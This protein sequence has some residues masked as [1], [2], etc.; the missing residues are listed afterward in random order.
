M[1][2]IVGLT[3]AGK[4]TLVN[5][6][7]GDYVSI[8]TPKPQTTRESLRAILHHGKSQIILTD[9]P[10]FFDSKTPRQH[11]M[12][13][14]ARRVIHTSEALLLLIDCLR[15]PPIHLL[16]QL[17]QQDIPTDKK[18]VVLNKIDRIDKKKL[19]PLAQ[20]IHTNAPDI[21]LWMVSARTNSGLEK[22]TRHMDS[23]ALTQPW[24]YPPDTQ[25]DQTLQQRACEL[26]REQLMRHLAHEIPYAI[27]VYTDMWH[28]DKKGYTI[29]QRIVLGKESHKAIVLGKGG[30]CIK[31]IGMRARSALTQQLKR[32]VQLFLRVCVHKNKNAPHTPHHTPTYGETP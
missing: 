15:L 17:R 10:G 6:L 24:P 31:A 23:I 30:A 16:H 7:I 22:L 21:S 25:S 28:D 13:K 2:G 14:T 26:T 19:L 9:S 27:D 32:D 20:K 5:A 3:N 8:A 11:A 18:M 1:V 12:L 29:R 4:S